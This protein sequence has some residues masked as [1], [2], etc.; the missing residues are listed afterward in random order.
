MQPRA[1]KITVPASKN[2]MET[3]EAYFERKHEELRLLNS[4]LR[5]PLNL[6]H[7]ESVTEVVRYKFQ[8]TAALR[9]EH[10][11]RDWTGTETAWSERP[12]AAGPFEFK[13]DYQRADLAVSGPSFYGK[14]GEFA[15]ET[16]YT[17]SGMA[18]ISALLLA[19]AHTKEADLLI[20]QGSYG[21]TLEFVEGYA[22]HLR[23]IP[24]GQSL[25]ETNGRAYS[26]R[27]LLLDSCAPGGAL[28]GTLRCSNAA[29][30]LLIFDTT[31]FS[32][33]SG[34]IRR[35]LNWARKWGVPVVMVRS[36]T[37][38]DSLGAEYGRL[39]S[40]TFIHWEEN[41][42]W[43]TGSKFK[44]LPAE[45]QNAIRLLGGAA[46]PAHFPPYI[47]TS[48]YRALT[49][50]RVAIILRNNRR[51]VEYFSSALPGLTVEHFAHGLYVK[52]G[53]TQFLD[54]DTA[55]QAAADMSSD[56]SRAGI[57]IRHAGSF[58]FDFAAV[59]WC[60]SSATHGYSV[61]LSVSDLPTRFW[62]DLIRA[63]AEWWNADRRS[64]V[65]PH[66]LPSTKSTS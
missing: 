38:L 23:L 51:A 57:P 58:G 43:I 1:L 15:Q 7:P 26:S 62:D 53:T 32:G 54:E 2:A 8:L 34:R 56:L 25:E 27:I 21:E 22:R 24:L 4:C 33:G 55:R 18:A 36:H 46:L 9:A 64:G 44:D 41:D 14:E 39:G 37:K 12:H 59:E 29:L 11:L 3:I 35:V 61:R 49:K 66:R 50:K 60:Q 17:G 16:T 52:L 45:T 28:E 47:G 10:A 5:S 63:V 40:A 48:N 6:T 65:N 31:C 42:P 30:D 13:Y 19:S 20:L